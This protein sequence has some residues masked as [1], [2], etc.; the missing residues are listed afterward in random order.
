M[1]HHLINKNETK[2]DLS[3]FLTDIVSFRSC[4]LNLYLPAGVWKDNQR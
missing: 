2:V 3:Y 4:S 1:S